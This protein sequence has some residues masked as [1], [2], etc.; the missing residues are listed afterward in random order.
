MKIPRLGRAPH[1]RR[2]QKP[3]GGPLLTNQRV[4]R[5]RIFRFLRGW[6][7]QSLKSAPRAVI[8]AGGL[9]SAGAASERFQVVEAR[10]E[11]ED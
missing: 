11:V 1:G 3:T 9:W 4:E 6:L 5:Q 2:A 8:G 7:Y 10:D